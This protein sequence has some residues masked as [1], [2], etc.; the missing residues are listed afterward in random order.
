MSEH[1]C[2]YPEA[3]QE[4]LSDVKACFEC[5]HVKDCSSVN[6][7]ITSFDQILFSVGLDFQE[8]EEKKVY[9]LIQLSTGEVKYFLTFKNAMNNCRRVGMFM[10]DFAKWNLLVRL[11]N[12]MDRT[13]RKLEECDA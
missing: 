4:S 13:I 8:D 9:Q 5:D 11:T 6:D 3:I 2:I 10:V 7:V 12:D 1:E